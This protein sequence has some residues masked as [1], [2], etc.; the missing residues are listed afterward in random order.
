MKSVAIWNVAANPMERGISQPV[1][2][3]QGNIQQSKNFGRAAAALT[4]SQ[5][6]RDG[7]QTSASTWSVARGSTGMKSER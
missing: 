3:R 4:V 1:Q 7:W 5:K 6:R 2:K